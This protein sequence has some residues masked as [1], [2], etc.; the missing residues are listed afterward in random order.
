MRGWGNAMLCSNSLPQ[1]VQSQLNEREECAFQPPKVIE[2]NMAEIPPTI[3]GYIPAFAA[4]QP[5]ALEFRQG[6]GGK[7]PQQKEVLRERK[8]KK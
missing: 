4:K 3:A 2:F 8:G 5:N 1:K 6:K 7:H